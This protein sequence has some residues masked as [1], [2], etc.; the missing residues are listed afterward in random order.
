MS[1]VITD[2]FQTWNAD[3][4]LENKPAVADK[5]V[6][7]LIPNQDPEAEISPSEGMPKPSEIVDSFD[8]TRIAKLG[9]NAVVYSIVLDTTVGDWAYN[10]VGLI[11]SKTNTVLMITHTDTQK[12][13]KTFNGK[14]GNSLIR[15]MVME[16][17]GAAEATQIT[18]TPETWQ[19]DFEGRINELEGDIAIQLSGKIDKVDITQELGTNKE[20]V[21][22]QALLTESLAD[23]EGD[24]RTKVNQ[25]QIT[26]EL[27]QA[28]DQI[29]SQ[30]LLAD[31]LSNTQT[32]LL[33]LIYPVGVVM[34]FAQNKNPNALIPNTTWQYIGENKTVRLAKKTG[35][36]VFKTGGNDSITLT[37]DQL[38][39]HS[40]T[41]SGKTNTFDHGSKSTSKNGKHTHTADGKSAFSTEGDM[42]AMVS[43]GTSHTNKQGI[44]DAGDHTHTV[45][46][47]E[48]H[49]TVSGK[50]ESIGK[51]KAI[52]ITNA[53]VML[54]GWY[55]TK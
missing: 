39:E 32:H 10:W 3:K 7:A 36:D 45:D 20:K 22:S 18:V 46:I 29:P 28:T 48:H 40:L 38:P 11:D 12:K 53:Y 52:D 33:N 47:G 25:S 37:T 30:K 15:N 55:R 51:N 41:F 19:I 9:D 4:I 34:W 31:S 23:I 49:H 21:V 35:E 17:S 5:I 26:Q 8:F 54:M 24:L 13:L 16:F 2:A 14:Q 44:K 50:T 43:N 42:F 6:F 27:G 1:S